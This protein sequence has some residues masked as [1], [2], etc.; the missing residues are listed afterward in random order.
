MVNPEQSYSEQE[1]AFIRKHWELGSTCLQIA[2]A[3][4]RSEKG[5][6]NKSRLMGLP[7]RQLRPQ[8]NWDGGK[9]ETAAQL[10]K[11]GLAASAIGKIVG[12]TRSAVIGKLY[13]AGLV[14]GARPKRVSLRPRRERGPRKRDQHRRPLNP[15]EPFVSLPTGIELHSYPAS[16]MELNDFTCRW[17]E[18]EPTANAFYCGGFTNGATYCPCHNKLAHNTGAQPRGVEQ[19]RGILTERVGCPA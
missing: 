14:R 10:W 11:E 4:N 18:G 13:R 6:Y 7:P 19:R 5:I 15:I 3:L 1:E 16:I 8:T 17:I 9:F 2:Y 12:A